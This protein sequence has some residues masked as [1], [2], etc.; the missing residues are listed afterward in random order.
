MY[1]VLA[2]TCHPD[3]M[4]IYAAGT[5]MKCV[6]RGEFVLRRLRRVLP[7]ADLSTDM[8]DL[9]TWIST[10]TTSQPEIRW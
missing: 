1:T 2:I 9:M 5:L 10:I 7:L 3:D 8:A 4:D 6:D